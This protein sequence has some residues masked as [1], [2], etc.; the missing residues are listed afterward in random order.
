MQKGMGRSRL[1]L[2]AW[3]ACEDALR[4]LGRPRERVQVLEFMMQLFP[5]EM[6]DRVRD[7]LLAALRA[8]LPGANPSDQDA[9]RRRIREL[10]G[11]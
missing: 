6:R 10:G 8:L 9:I 7:Q 4:N 3:W 5:K 1:D 2:D 11:R